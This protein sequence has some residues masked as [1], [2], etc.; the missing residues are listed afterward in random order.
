MVS[1]FDN[2]LNRDVLRNAEIAAAEERGGNY[3]GVEPVTGRSIPA[4]A[5]GFQVEENNAVRA[6]LRIALRIAG[7]IVQR[8]TLYAGA[9]RFDVENTVEWRLGRLFRIEQLFPIAQQKPVSS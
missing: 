3:I 8:L 6:I 9:K 5:D 2:E 4:V 7:P 1:L